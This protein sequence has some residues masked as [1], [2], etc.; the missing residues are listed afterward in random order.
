MYNEHGSDRVN[1]GGS[2]FDYSGE[3]QGLGGV[4]L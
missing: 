2:I 3:G 1:K 4:C